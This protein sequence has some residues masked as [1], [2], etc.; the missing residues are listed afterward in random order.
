[1]A[2]PLRAVGADARSVC[3]FAECDGSGWILGPE[4]V[5]RPC[6]CRDRQMQ[7]RR[8]LGINSAIPKRYRDVSL[9]LLRNDGISP[10][11]LGVVAGLVEDIDAML[12]E[13]RGLWLSGSVGN[14]KTSV[15]MLVSKAAIEAGR[16]VAIYSLPKLLTRI[17][18]TFGD[19]YIGDSYPRL[20]ERLTSIDLLH[21]DD[22]GAEK[23]SEWML[24]QLYSIVNE[25]YEA[26]RSILITTNLD[27]AELEKQIGE[28]TVSRLLEM[29]GQ[30]IIQGDD[31]RPKL[32]PE[33]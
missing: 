7:R 32:A 20:F 15:A 14:G 27:E 16:S 8:V 18:A 3:P 17:R 33:V 1:M 19:D 10:T 30:V 22:L 13:G 21:I 2:A 12:D 23:Q 11:V 4:D 29:C 28:R 25:R 5:A 6:R 9:D 31:R 24:E 26:Q